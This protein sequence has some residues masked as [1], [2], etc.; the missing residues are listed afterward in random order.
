MKEAGSK[1]KMVVSGQNYPALLQKLIVQGLIKI[2]EMEVVVYCRSEDV[3]TVT[4]ILPKAVEEYVTIM[5]KE[6]GVTLHPKVTVNADRARDLPDSSN[7]GVKLTALN[8]KIVL[9]NT[10]TSRLELVYEELMPSIRAILFP[11]AE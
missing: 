10:M 7:G 9:D 11:E 5:K 1:C 4:K 6:S 2:E 3:T 8:G